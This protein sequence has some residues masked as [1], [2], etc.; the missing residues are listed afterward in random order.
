MATVARIH[1]VDPPNRDNEL[2]IES[3]SQFQVY[4][5]HWKGLKNHGGSPKVSMK[6]VFNLHTE[7][8]II[9]IELIKCGEI[10]TKVHKWSWVFPKLW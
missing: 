10:Y 4:Q 9:H 7:T 2:G 8:I 5:T 6:S 3:S 1:T